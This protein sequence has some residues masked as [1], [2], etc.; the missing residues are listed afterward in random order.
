MNRKGQHYTSENCQK[1]GE[2]GRP[3]SGVGWAGFFAHRLQDQKYE[4]INGGGQKSNAPIRSCG[5]LRSH[6]R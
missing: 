3:Y 4:L 1:E 2:W 5:V 6:R